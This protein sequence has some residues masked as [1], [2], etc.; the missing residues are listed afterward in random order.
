MYQ[1][2]LGGTIFM[3]QWWV[4]ECGEQ[5]EG[6]G[7]GMGAAGNHIKETKAAGA[8]HS[9]RGLVD[10]DTGELLLKGL[11]MTGARKRGFVAMK[12]RP[13]GEA[14]GS[15]ASA[16][17]ASA[18]PVIRE[19]TEDQAARALRSEPPKELT[20]PQT[21]S[22]VRGVLE[23]WTFVVPAPAFSLFMLGRETI[24]RDD[25]TPYPMTPD[26]FQAYFW[27]AFRTWHEDH[28]ALLLGLPSELPADDVELIVGRVMQRITETTYLRLAAWNGGTSPVPAPPAEEE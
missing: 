19:V 13:G 14:A 18:R 9:I 25:G 15:P 23:T 5:W 4:C 17:R 24:R 2:G 11:D 6:D 8:K 3:A 28:M 20:R 27:E 22:N 7:R 26:G 1:H 21:V 16:P 10:L 12:G